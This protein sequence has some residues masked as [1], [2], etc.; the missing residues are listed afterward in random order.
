MIALIR[1]AWKTPEEEL[2]GELIGG[3]FG[4]LFGERVGGVIREQIGLIGGAE[5]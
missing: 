5:T 2:I 1:V 3:I 4:G